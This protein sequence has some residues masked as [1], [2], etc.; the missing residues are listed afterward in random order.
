M[1]DHQIVDLYWSR[2]EQAIAQSQL[3]YGRMLQSVSYSLLHSHEDAEECVSDTYI[4]AWN[5]MPEERPQYLGAFLS[6]IVRHI[7]IS[8]FRSAHRQKRGG[9]DNLVEELTECIPDRNTVQE[10]Y[11]NGRL[12]EALNGFLHEMEE[13]RRAVFLRRYFYGQSIEQIAA[14][15]GIKAGSVK[16]MLFRSREALRSVLEKEE[17]L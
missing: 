14:E 17:L 9:M 2:S 16:S 1:E 4:A 10:E 15:T 7:S 6:K 11:E 8:R 3:K 13:Q 12:A 5:R